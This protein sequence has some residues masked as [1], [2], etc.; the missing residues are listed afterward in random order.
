MSGT[1]IDPWRDAKPASRPGPCCYCG[2]RATLIEP[3]GNSPAHK[4]CAQRAA[5]VADVDVRPGTGGD[6]ERKALP[7]VPLGCGTPEPGQASG[8]V[9]AAVTGEIYRLG[10]T[11]SC[12]LCPASPTYWRHTLS[13]FQRAGLPAYSG[14]ACPPEMITLPAL[15]DGAEA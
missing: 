3:G 13:E 5:G 7:D 12:Q 15:P 10:T 14:P 8:R 11:P 9:C 6:D 2:A 4:V 1:Y